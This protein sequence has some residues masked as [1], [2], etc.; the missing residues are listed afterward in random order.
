MSVVIS[1]EEAGPWRRKLTIEVPWPAVA[2]ETGRVIQEINKSIR[3]KGFRKG[4]VPAS[5][6][7]KRFPQEIEQKLAERLVPRYW[8]Q[9][10]A[11]KN[12][13]ALV[14]PRFEEVKIEED[15]PMTFV[16]VVDTRPEIELGELG[17]FELPGGSVEA[18]DEDIDEL[19][20]DLRRQHAQWEPVER[21]AAAGD[22][23][24]G[25]AVDVTDPEKSVIE[26]LQVELGGK[27]VAEELT[28]ALTG[29]TVGQS[30]SFSRPEGEGEAA[31]ELRYRIEATE[32]KEQRLPELDDAFAL[33]AGGVKTVEELRAVAGERLGERKQ[34][35]L[36]QQRERA[37]LQQLCE[38]HPLD[39][40][41]GL[42]DHELEGM[43]HE[44]A[45]SLR[46]R[47]VELEQA[48]I[49]WEQLQIKLRPQAQRRVHERLLLDAVAK[50]R[51]LKVDEKEFERILASIATQQKKNS[52]AV[53]QELAAAGRLQPLRAE[54]LRDQAL[55]HLLGD[56]AAETTS[57]QDA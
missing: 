2:A 18:S 3:L 46:A 19:L 44:Y 50:E 8:R 11:E 5:V 1:Y 20:V 12:L 30:T 15:T 40:S 22:L 48:Q 51:D 28:L 39:L 23:V 35:E 33:R 29:I 27:G 26:P 53:R 25:Q 4:K 56:D 49:D 55:R 10:E 14:P 45:E 24:I 42:I 43:M 16:A 7:R 32:V 37:L 21:P 36:R 38:R 57:E 52:L 41:A 17:D 6:I 13:E 31:R 47:G 54:L 9:A 34:R